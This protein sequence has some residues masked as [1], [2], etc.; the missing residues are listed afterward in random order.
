M[1]QF[2]IVGAEGAPH[3]APSAP[4]CCIV[5]LATVGWVSRQAGWTS[6][7]PGLYDQSRL[8]MNT[9]DNGMAASLLFVSFIL[10]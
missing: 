5:L 7:W 1:S 3:P 9:G 4:V 6:E 8:Y 2:W 10:R